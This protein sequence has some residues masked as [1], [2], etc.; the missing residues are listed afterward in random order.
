MPK[1]LSS[2][3]L[4]GFSPASGKIYVVI[5]DNERRAI[6]RDI[7]NVRD[8]NLK[9][10]LHIAAFHGRTQVMSHFLPNSDIVAQDIIGQ[11]ALHKAVLGGHIDVVRLLLP[12]HAL[13]DMRRNDGQTPLDVARDLEQAYEGETSRRNIKEL[14]EDATR[15]LQAEAPSLTLPIV[16][17]NATEQT[18]TKQRPD[19]IAIDI[20]PA[21]SDKTMD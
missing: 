13:Y 16:P 9:T 11:T 7:V 6:M 14:L 12:Y 20:K 18:L 5:L 15:S 10:P 17:R 21:A 8:Y 3:V 19:F 2:I 1:H 4:R